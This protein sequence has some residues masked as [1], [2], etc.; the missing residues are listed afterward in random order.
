MLVLRDF[1]VYR[2]HHNIEHM[3]KLGG[4]IRKEV[5]R[6]NSKN[7]DYGFMFAKTP[8]RPKYM[9]LVISTTA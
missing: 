5:R 3:I 6:N 2:M 9:I 4:K 1:E 7:E 8:K